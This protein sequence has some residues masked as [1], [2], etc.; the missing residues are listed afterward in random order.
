[1]RQTLAGEKLVGRKRV[2]DVV[3]GEFWCVEN[4]EDFS[5]SGWLEGSK[6]LGFSDEENEGNI[7]LKLFCHDQTAKELRESLRRLRNLDIHVFRTRKLDKLR[8]H[9]RKFLNFFSQV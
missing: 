3:V 6:K 2:R 7:I 1:L 5:W 8:F 4:F 9:I